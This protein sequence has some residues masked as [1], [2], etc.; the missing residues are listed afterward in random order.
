MLD[1]TLSHATP[2]ATK[3]KNFYEALGRRIAERRRAQDI[4]QVQLAATLGIAQQTMAHYE[5]GVSRIAVAMLSQL[6]TALDTTVED[7]IGLPAK[8]TASK[9]GPAPK[10]QQQLERIT[11]LPK[12][13]QRFVMQMLDTVLQQQGG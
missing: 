10:L 4:T 9:R 12:A 5:G 7:L 3:E 2:M 6:A 1:R 8:R 13:Q 11:Q